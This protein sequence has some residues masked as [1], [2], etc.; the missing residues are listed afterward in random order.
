M[1]L[2]S[3]EMR[4]VFEEL[5]TESL[6]E[7]PL[8]KFDPEENVELIVTSTLKKAARPNHQVFQHYYDCLKAGSLDITRYFQPMEK[9]IMKSDGLIKQL[10]RNFFHEYTEKVEEI[11]QRIFKKVTNSI[12]NMHQENFSK[13]HVEKVVEIVTREIEDWNER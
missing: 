5:W 4:A 12:A 13:A 9:Y 7:L 6:K 3:K 11:T 2:S 10:W 1:K 8:C